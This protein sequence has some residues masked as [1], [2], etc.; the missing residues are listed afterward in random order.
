[1]PICLRVVQWRRAGVHL[2][3]AT[4]ER[5]RADVRVRTCDHLPAQRPPGGGLREGERPARD[6]VAQVQEAGP[7]EGGQGLVPC[8]RAVQGVQLAVCPVHQLDGAALGVVHGDPIGH[9]LQDGVEALG[10]LARLRLARLRPGQRRLRPLPSVLL[11]GVEAGA[12]DRQGDAVGGALQQRYVGLREAVRCGAAH[13]EHPHQP[14]HQVVLHRVLHQQR[15]AGDRAQPLP[16]EGGCP[17]EVGG[18]QRASVHDQGRLARRDAADE[19]FPHRNLHAADLLFPQ[20]ARRPHGQRLAVGVQQE[21]AD[22]VRAHHGGHAAEQ[23][24]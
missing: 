23:L 15:H 20:P 12:V 17:L 2:Q 5:P 6:G 22:G 24:T 18:R 3:L 14:T 7:L 13:A 21:D 1:M 11:G 9:G 10:T 16:K 4:V 19:R 8:R